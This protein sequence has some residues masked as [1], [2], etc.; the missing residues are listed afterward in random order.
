M[1]GWAALSTAAPHG[2]LGAAAAARA[3][4]LSA[5]RPAVPL[6]H[7]SGLLLTARDRSPGGEVAGDPA[8]AGGEVRAAS[9]SSSFSFCSSCQHRPVPAVCWG[10]GGRKDPLF[11]PPSGMEGWLRFSLSEGVLK[12]V[13]DVRLNCFL[14]S[15][16]VVDRAGKAFPRCEGAVQAAS[17]LPCSGA[18]QVA[19]SRIC[20]GPMTQ[21]LLSAG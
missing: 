20:N 1:R 8:A 18:L 7:R 9:S 17:Y 14:P 2:G 10:A 19:G 4:P 6:R 16:S 13:L 21:S 12:Y 15:E 11:P 3:P 5:E